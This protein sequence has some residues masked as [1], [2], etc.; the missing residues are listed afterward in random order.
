MDEIDEEIL[1]GS[2]QLKVVANVAVGYNNIGVQATSR[3][4]VKVRNTAGVLDDTIADFVRCAPQ[5]RYA[6]RWP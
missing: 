4:K 5:S 1:A 6:Q 2:P 3:R